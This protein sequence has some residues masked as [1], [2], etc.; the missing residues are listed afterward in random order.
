MTMLLRLLWLLIASGWLL[1]GVARAQAPA[2]TD[3]AATAPDLPHL[4][5]AIAPLPDTSRMNQLRD[6]NSRLCMAGRL[7]E[8]SQVVTQLQQLA[9]RIGTPDQLAYAWQSAGHVASRQGPNTKAIALF[10]RGYQAACQPR[11]A[12]LPPSR[13][14][15]AQVRLLLNIAIQ[16][17][18]T[19][20]I[21]YAAR[22]D[23]QALA[24]ARQHGLVLETAMANSSLANV[25]HHQQNI[26]ALLA[27]NA[28]ALRGYQQVRRFDK[29]YAASI[30]RAGILAD[31]GRYQEADSLFRRILTYAQ[32]TH[33]QQLLGEVYT[34]W[35]TT[36]R[37][38]H[39]PAEAERLALAGLAWAQRTHDIYSHRL[40]VYEFLASLKEE[41]GDY[42]QALYYQRK[43]YIFRDSLFNQQKNQQLVEAETRYQT[44]EKQA[45]IKL[46]NQRNGL[47]ARLTQQQQRLLWGLS[48]G[49]AIVLLLLTLVLRQRR[50][51]RRANAHL[52]T[53]NRTVSEQ[54][55]RLATLLQE[56]HHRVKNNLATVAS[57]LRL[58]SNRLTDATALK[59]VQESRQRVEAMSLIHQRLYQGTEVTTVDMRAYLHDLT[60]SLLR[61]YGL[62]P[63]AVDLALAVPEPALDV[64]LAIPMGLIV[65]ELLTNSLKHALPHVA[66]LG[67]RIELHQQPGAGL[68]LEVEDNGPGFEAAQP[69]PTSFGRRLITVLSEQLNGEMS[70]CGRAGA[71]Y[72][73]HIPANALPA[74]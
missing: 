22:Y 48:L 25:A 39:R 26:P 66:R 6:F 17:I 19:R 21:A 33:S 49:L 10:R 46:L 14:Y 74:A 2:P 54:A 34:S 24:L 51:L 23:Q 18:A 71:C 37:H 59:A 72:R 8:A 68:T 7:S 4:L 40:D 44:A 73:L 47:L 11:P 69:A 35:P 5:A 12:G 53:T 31:L 20:N 50:Q 61:A 16:Y 30:L 62:A 9:R 29:Y 27:Y 70:E 58:Q 55:H 42:R 56:L 13:Y 38:L 52:A 32:R 64:D 63:H 28:A 60:E 1:A 3:P 67:L 36:L 65:N 43:G 45:R 15:A 41:Q 57:L